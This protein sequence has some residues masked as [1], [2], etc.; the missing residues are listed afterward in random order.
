MY[1]NRRLLSRAK[2]QQVLHPD[3]LKMKQLQRHMRH[4]IRVETAKGVTKQKLHGKAER[5]LWFRDCIC[6]CVSNDFRIG[7]QCAL[8][9]AE[10]EWLVEK[11][12]TRLDSDIKELESRRNPP[13]GQIKTLKAIQEAESTQYQSSKGIDIPRLTDSDALSSLVGWLGDQA[14]VGK[15]PSARWTKHVDAADVA[16]AST[17]FAALENADL[18]PTVARVRTTRATAVTANASNS[19]VGAKRLSCGEALARE[20]L[21]RR[22]LQQVQRATAR[23]HAALAMSRRLV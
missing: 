16:A 1:K 12:L 15:V 8:S 9:E 17:R 7:E 14:G 5:F 19:K 13:A 20:G 23:R 10:V 11:Y 2:Q 18:Q 22:T 6:R 21:K 4:N 3:S